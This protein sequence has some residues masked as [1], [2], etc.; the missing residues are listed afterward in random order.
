[1]SQPDQ[2]PFTKPMSPQE[3]LDA[4]LLKDRHP[5]KRR[6]QAARKK[7]G[8]VDERLLQALQ[9]SVAQVEKRRAVWPKIDYPDLPVS[10]Q[11][12]AIQKALADNQVLV[13]AG[14]TGS[15]KTTQL[16]KICLEMGLGAQGLIGHTQPRRLAA[17]S[18]AQR[19]AEEL[20][21]PLGQQVGYQV[22]FQDQQTDTTLVKLMTDGILLAET[23]K[24]PFLNRYQVIII[25]EA[26]ERSLNIDFLLGYLKRLLPK[27]PD[28]KL[29]I[30]SATIDVERFSQHFSN[31]PI[32][33]VSGRTY[34]VETL[35][36][37]LL[38]EDPDTED[39]T[40]QE[41]I[42]EALEEIQT[43]ERQKGWLHGPRDVLVFLPGEREIR[44]V[45]HLIRRQQ[46]SGRFRDTEV[47]PL[48]ARLPASEQQRVFQT[49]SGRRVVLTTNVAETSLT[50][51]GIRY[52]IDP[53]T[54]RISR[55]SYRAGVQR[56]PIEPVSQ[57]SANQRAGRCGRIAEGL[58]IRLYSE[59]D[60]VSRP[61]FTE[62]EIRR[63][64]LAAVILQM[65]SL[66][67]GA[68]EDFPFVEPPD[69]RFIKDGFRLLF[70]LGAVNA[71]NQLT[72]LGRKLARLPVDPRLARMLLE[73]DQRSCL[74][75][76][77]VITSALNLQDPRERPAD[78]Q[79]AADQA[80]A[81]WKDPDSDFLAL[82]NLWNFYEEKRQEVSGNQLRKDCKKLFLSYMRMRE[83]RDTHRQLK[84]LAKELGLKENTEPASYAA[85][86]QALLSGLLSNMGMLQENKE[87]LGA[88]NRKFFIHPGSKAGKKTPKWIMAAEL[89]ETT[90]LFA[91][92]IAKIDPR[93]AEPL[94]EHLVKCSHSDPHWEKK[95]ARVAALEK[96]TLFGLP[97]VTGRKVD[98]GK[99][100]PVEARELFIRSALV[101][102]QYQT[103]APFM[104]HNQ[105]LLNAVQTLED[106]A[107]KKDILVDDQVLYD[108]YDS[109]IP[110]DINKG[111]SFESWRKQAEQEQPNLLFLTREALL[112]RT[113]D[114]VTAEAY[115]DTLRWEGVEWQLSYHFAPG[116]ADDGVSITVPVAMLGQLPE[117][118]LEWL[119]PGLLEEKCLALMRGL[120][121]AVRKN[122]VP[123]PDYVRAALEAL[124]PDD[125]PL[126]KALGLF[127][128]KITGNRID[129]ALWQQVDLPDHLR[130]NFKVVDAQGKPLGQGRDLAALQ[131]RFARQM[132][133]GTQALDAGDLQVT[134]R[135]DWDFADLP[136]RLEQV[137][138]GVKLQAFPALVDEGQSVGV[139]LVDSQ[140]K[141]RMA[142]EKGLVR[143]A[144]LSLPQKEKYLQS[145]LPGLKN[146][147]LLYAKIGSR[148]QLVDDLL[149]TALRE[150]LFQGKDAPWPRTAADFSAWLKNHE[151]DWV[152]K[153]TEKVQQVEAALKAQ[154]PLAA[155]LKG[156]MNLALALTFKDA[157][158]Q[159]ARL[160][161][162]GFIW[163][164]GHW[165]QHYPRYLKAL[166][167]RL[168]KAARDRLRDQRNADE[169]EAWWQAWEARYQQLLPK[170]EVSRELMDF[171]WL[172]EEY[173]VSLYAQQLGTSESISAKRLKTY[174]SQLVTD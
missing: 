120:P 22:R 39:L 45:A 46:G 171:R 142:T 158:R 133:A 121:K 146:L 109:R 96:V 82:V 136:E 58:C 108:F 144:R 165:L 98:F 130:M 14:E 72:G 95:A 162:P 31:C 128:Y 64:N 148:Q 101:E 42:L 151:A 24:D 16:P 112:A 172:L 36:R 167:L 90:R 114:E 57:A 86:H 49:H 97:L 18:V 99:I 127:L 91:R 54:A 20:Q 143:L 66:R 88:R 60:F 15:G 40:Q 29:V 94:A 33:E 154:V 62:P 52:V 118:R 117:G 21:V 107:R 5:L 173:R 122:F 139:T 174:W 168:E 124:V 19:L 65:L 79:Q 89:V 163:D 12:E 111:A 161:Y 141:A 73:A 102:G 104:A 135:T 38:S 80:H 85:L 113:A 70:E 138:A 157:Q 26:H 84:L 149:D 43:L 9:A 27:R 126:G 159:L 17:R 166:E 61:E 6:W 169:V 76:M 92:M 129:E 75:E 115:P 71:K 59:E 105:A 28:L 152:P 140:E 25:D 100:Q 131:K 77:L 51:P 110:E 44:E 156:K 106:K 170:G 1:M 134:G 32:I 3:L 83:W 37:P 123:L 35:Y 10:D 132:E 145:Q 53:G 78:H 119:V 2:P 137:Q 116:E 34:P 74:Q 81:Q 48:Y 147:Q 4:C 30:T 155:Q 63:T 8:G 47:L 103:R 68:V 160:F 87:Y 56:L 125:L 11:R 150:A 93:W 153:A 164:S 23:Q 41:G 13:V 67:L 55:Y 69:S 7:A 50:V